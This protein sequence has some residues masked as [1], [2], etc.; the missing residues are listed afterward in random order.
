ME[1]TEYDDEDT[2]QNVKSFYGGQIQAELK[3]IFF[4]IN[5]SRTPFTNKTDK[6]YR[7][8]RDSGSG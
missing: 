8:R 5:I 3:T 7:P 6:F 2:E 1:H 4:Q